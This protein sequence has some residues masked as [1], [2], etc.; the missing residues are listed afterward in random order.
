MGVGVGGGPVLR[1]VSCS[2]IAR[3][4]AILT[5]LLLKKLDQFVGVRELYYWG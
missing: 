3:F 1:P 5:A 4:E 2:R